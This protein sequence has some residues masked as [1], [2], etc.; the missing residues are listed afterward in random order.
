MSHSY[1]GDRRIKAMKLK[2]LFIKPTFRC[3]ANCIHCRHRR[4]LYRKQVDKEKLTLDHFKQLFLEANRLGT[5]SLHISGGEPTLYPYLMELVRA[6]KQYS[7]FVILNSNGS[8]MDSERASNL[9]KSGLDAIILSIHSANPQIHDSMRQRDGMWEKVVRC[10]KLMS[11][12]KREINPGFIL[13]TQTIVTRQ[14]YLDLHNIL[15]LVS[16]MA[17]D[18]HAF[19]YLEGDFERK[20]LLSEK[21]I[22]DFKRIIVPKILH[23]LDSF[24]Y[25]SSVLK[26]AARRRVSR[27]FDDR[28][29][30]L[31]DYACGVYQDANAFSCNAPNVFAMILPNGDV[32][33]CNMVEYVHEP[34]VGNVLTE[35][36][37]SIWYGDRFNEFRVKRFEWCRFCPTHLHFHVPLGIKIRQLAQLAFRNPAPEQ[38]SIREQIARTFTMTK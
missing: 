32:H 13:M 25:K 12:A 6:G 33:P 21:E 15:G 34:V 30:S 10:V 36:L 28:N 5:D 24:P 4:E 19:S 11:E 29:V 20:Q 18:A 22:L 9:L 31:K 7:W 17:V 3:S 1:G 8:E 38:R 16:Q 14:N 37:A 23:R 35:S 26:Y 2:S 27:F